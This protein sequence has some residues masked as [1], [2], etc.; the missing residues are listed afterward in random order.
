MPIPKTLAGQRGGSEV[1]VG[2]GDGS[3]KKC[4]IPIFLAET[5]L[6]Y[7]EN[8]QLKAPRERFELTSLHLGTPVV[9][10]EPS[11]LFPVLSKQAK[12]NRWLMIKID[13]MSHEHI[14]LKAR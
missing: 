7:V 2:A 9:T 1:L 13:I 4:S 14:Y 10:P 11:L 12:R 3:R 6:A 5:T 8:G